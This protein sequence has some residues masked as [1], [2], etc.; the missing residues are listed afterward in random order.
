MRSLLLLDLWPRGGLHGPVG[1]IRFESISVRSERSSEL[2]NEG[3]ERRGQ[4]LMLPLWRERAHSQRMTFDKPLVEATVLQRYKRF[5]VDAELASGEVV[6]AHCPNTGSMRNCIAPGWRAALSPATTPGRRCP[7]TLE[8]THNGRCWIAVHTGRT[9]TVA[10]EGIATG[11]I[12]ELGNYPT[13]K[14]EQKYGRNSR[15][16]ILLERGDERCYVEVKSVT[17]TMDDG[18][19]A[20]PDAVTGRGL[21]HLRE[22]S[23]AVRQGHRAVMLFLIQRSDG[24]SFRAAHEIDP[25]YARGMRSAA[26]AGVELLAYRARISRRSMTL[27]ER[28][29]ILPVGRIPRKRTRQRARN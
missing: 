19:Y 2:G 28:I 18:H 6:T 20:F 24:D 27:A 15:I 13:L 11:R 17:M 7:Y 1:H 26:R 4:E 21:K 23:A 10:A 16:D 5:L 25:D 12:P 22:L 9:N 3:R 14:R 8:L 29:E